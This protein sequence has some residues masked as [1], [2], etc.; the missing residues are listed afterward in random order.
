MKAAVLYLLLIA[1][2]VAGDLSKL[3]C[4]A[5]FD[6]AAQNVTTSAE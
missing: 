5:N 4:P 6:V 2:A 3:N 1:T